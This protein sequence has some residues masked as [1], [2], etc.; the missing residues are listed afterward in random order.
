MP[1]TSS[2]LC[3]L[4][5]SVNDGLPVL[6]EGPVGCGKTS[7]VEYLAEEMGQGGE[8]VKLQLGDQMDS[9]VGLICFV[10]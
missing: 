10:Y 3:R 7:L 9:K 4:K 1:S 8:L 2:N 6:L 5:L